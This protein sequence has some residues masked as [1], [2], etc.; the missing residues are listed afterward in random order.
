MRMPR[1]GAPVSGA[2]DEAATARTPGA[3]R[4]RSS[5]PLM[6]RIFFAGSMQAVLPERLDVRRAQVHFRE[7]AIVL[8]ESEIDP[9]G[10]HEAD[11]QQSGADQQRLRQRQLADHERLVA[12]AD[13]RGCPRRAGRCG[14]D[15]W[16]TCAPS[17]S[18]GPRPN[19][20]A[21]SSVIAIVN[22]EHRR[23]DRDLRQPRQVLRRHE[24]RARARRRPRSE[25]GHAAGHRDDQRFDQQLP[26]DARSIGAERVAHRDLGLPRRR[27]GR[28]AD[29]RR[30][31]TR[32][33]AAPRPRS[34]AA[35]PAAARRRR[36]LRASGTTLAPRPA[37]VDG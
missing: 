30:S 25:A 36:S 4:T 1:F 16:P 29:A 26:H 20:I 12:A 27:P 2:V 33:A 15:R 24:L 8:R 34:A 7:H 9:R 37:L 22:G 28:A 14:R 3:P 31:R 10:V 11:E 5:T 17:A 13:A 23:V 32:S 18:P 6:K 19:T 21:V 35:R